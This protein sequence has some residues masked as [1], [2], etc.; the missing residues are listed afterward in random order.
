MR[1]IIERKS[2][3]GVRVFVRVLAKLGCTK[4]GIK[5]YFIP[6]IR[7]ELHV[8]RGLLRTLVEEDDTCIVG[9]YDLRVLYN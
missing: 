1:N 9:P 3:W 4:S 8:V 6:T 5:G 2:S 7:P